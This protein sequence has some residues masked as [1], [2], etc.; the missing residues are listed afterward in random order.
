MCPPTALTASPY[1]PT[2]AQI[3]KRAVHPI[4]IHKPLIFSY[5]L[6]LLVG[7]W[8]AFLLARWRARAVG[9]ERR[10]IDNL[11]ILLVLTGLGG[12]RFFNRVFYSSANVLTLDSLKIWEGGGLVLYGGLLTGAVCFIVY[13][14]F[15]KLPI[16]TMADVVTPSLAV[17]LF[18]GR[19][20]CFLAGCCWGCICDDPS[21][22]LQLLA[23]R[24][25]KSSLTYEQ[26]RASGM[27][28]AD[29][30]RSL[31]VH[32]V[33]LYEAFSM[34]LLFWV[35]MRQFKQRRFSGEIFCLFALSYAAVRF[36]LEFLRAD[37]PSDYLGM[38]ISQ[39][40]SI[41]V[42]TACGT[43]FFIKRL[44]QN[45]RGISASTSSG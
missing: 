33:Q 5:P 34:L 3:T 17:G 1:A 22:L 16:L 23:V 4:L 42:A 43:T 2:V 31:A 19:I 6:L 36:W 41:L 10:H 18:F 24:F 15:R 12:A 28:S 29:A 37:N 26:H 14:F 9:I 21:N 38:T 11:T 32:P 8:C 45:R 44:L 30:E 20:G 27:L 39:V 13:A 25:P 40:I 35:L 7:L